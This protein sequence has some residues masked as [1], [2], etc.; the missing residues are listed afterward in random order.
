MTKQKA[1]SKKDNPHPVDIHVGSR[2]K[3]RRMVMGVSQDTL[4]KAMGLTFQQIQKYEKG[5]NRISASKIYE[6]S[7]QLEV[8]IQ[9][10]FEDYAD[11]PGYTYGFAEG[12]AGDPFMQLV[13]SPEGIQLCRCFASIK[14]PEVKKKVLDLVKS[15][16][17][18]ENDDAS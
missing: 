10:F 12:E 11:G 8:P 6:L 1:A 9:Y 15:I 7:H 17:E 16:A 5:V 2:V 4:G 14:D 13:Q 18:S 3:L